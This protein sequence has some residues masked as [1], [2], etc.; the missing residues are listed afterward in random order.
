MYLFIFTGRE[1]VINFFNE[2]KNTIVSIIENSKK[3]L[4]YNSEDYL[5][6][7]NIKILKIYA[8]LRRVYYL[9]RIL[10]FFMVYCDVKNPNL[11][12]KLAKY[13]L[14]LCKYLVKLKASIDPISAYCKIWRGIKILGLKPK[15]EI[16]PVDFNT[17]MRGCAF[18]IGERHYLRKKQFCIDSLL[19]YF[20][21][22]EEFVSK[23]KPNF[24]VT[25]IVKLLSNIFKLFDNI[26]RGCNPLLLRQNL[27]KDPPF[28]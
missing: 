4:S 22:E 23:I 14:K 26:A 12:P 10:Q 15:T 8:E 11:V 6:Q 27:N 19:R 21:E 1:Q 20:D 25:N 17:A 3:I 16:N 13:Y 18:A 24:I 5:E 2:C 7:L 28:Y 9:K